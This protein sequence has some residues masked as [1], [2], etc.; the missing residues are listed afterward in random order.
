L[1]KM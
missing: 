1:I